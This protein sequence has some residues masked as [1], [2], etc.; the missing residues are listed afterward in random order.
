VYWLTNN[1]ISVG[2]T[3]FFNNKRIARAFDIPQLKDPESVERLEFLARNN[4][5]PPFKPKVLLNHKPKLAKS[6]KN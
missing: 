6:N 2:Q 1:I 4:F 5:K 3:A